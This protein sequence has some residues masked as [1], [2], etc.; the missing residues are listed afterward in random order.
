MPV[1]ISRATKKKKAKK[2]KRMH[3]PVSKI[4]DIVKLFA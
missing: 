3:K 1:L 4:D 2:K